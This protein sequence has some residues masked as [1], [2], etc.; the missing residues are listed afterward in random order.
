MI[1]NIDIHSLAIAAAL[2]LI[3]MVISRYLKLGMEM[4]LG[5][6][7]VRMVL[8][9]TAVGFILEAV[10]TTQNAA[11]A[12]VVFVIMMLFAA[13]EVRARLETR[14]QGIA[15]WFVC[16][17]G[18]SIASV[19]MLLFLLRGIIQPQPWWNMQYAVPLFG[20]LLGNSMTSTAL[21]INNLLGALWRDRGAIENTLA[22]GEPMKGA[23]LR[24]IKHSIT[25]GTMPITNSMAAT[26]VVFLPGLMV[27]QILS[28]VSPLIAVKY[29]MLI[30][31]ALTSCATLAVIICVLLIPMILTDKRQRLRFDLLVHKADS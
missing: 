16:G 11:L 4:K 21:M 3:N 25:A 22:R 2:L 8:Q 29:Q 15:G 24:P 26:G 28:G 18:L 31:F 6:A 30:M 23:L 17:I 27:G 7:A 5:V 1:T 19:A 14:I 9:L 12:S 10:I 20:M 13:R